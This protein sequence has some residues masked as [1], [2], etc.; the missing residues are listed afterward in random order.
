M[1]I[2]LIAGALTLALFT[3]AAVKPP[4]VTHDDFRW[5]EGLTPHTVR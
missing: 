2:L 3:S 5:A 1:K 4:L